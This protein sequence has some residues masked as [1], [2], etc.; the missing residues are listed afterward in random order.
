MES[1]CFLADGGELQQRKR[2]GGPGAP[3]GRASRW[4]GRQASGEELPRKAE[5]GS[6]PSFLQGAAPCESPPS[7]LDSVCVSGL[8]EAQLRD[9]SHPCLSVTLGKNPTPRRS[10]SLGPVVRR[11]KALGRWNQAPCKA[12]LASSVGGRGLW[13]R[14]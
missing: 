3:Q 8:S 14:A 2:G 7:C 10:G 11:C 6:G 9:G 12:F 5:S 13:P 1:S 4:T